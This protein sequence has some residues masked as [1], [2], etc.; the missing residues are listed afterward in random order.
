MSVGRVNRVERPPTV[1]KVVAFARDQISSVSSSAQRAVVWF[2]VAATPSVIACSST[3]ANECST[4]EVDGGVII[5]TAADVELARGIGSVSGV[6]RISLNGGGPGPRDLSFLGCLAHATTLM[7][8]R[9]PGLETTAGANQLTDLGSLQISGPEELERIEG[10]EGLDEIEEIYV[11]D[12]P[13]VLAIDLPHIE[14][15]GRLQVGACDNPP[16]DP[17]FTPRNPALV[18]VGPFESIRSLKELVV[19][20]NTALTRL[21]VLKS[22]H[23]NGAPP[24]D[25]VGIGNNPQL[26]QSEIDADLAALGIDAAK[27]ESGCGNLGSE[28]KLCTCQWEE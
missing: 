28:E 12:A 25:I 22:L 14:S 10:F 13:A 9:A 4:M 6:L 17:F 2:C 24:I 23:D 16:S 26:P 5:S 11:A 18:E 1:A 8:L 20:S 27:I 15:V 21:S 3:A 19:A 7:I